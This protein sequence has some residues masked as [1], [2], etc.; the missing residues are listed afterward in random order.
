LGIIIGLD[1]HYLETAAA[2]SEKIYRRLER[3]RRGGVAAGGLSVAEKARWSLPNL[4]R[5]GGVGPLAWRQLVGALR[6]Y[7]WMV[8]GAIFLFAML[9]PM[10]VL[11]SQGDRGEPDAILAVFCS[12]TFFVALFMP[13]LLTFDFRADV[14]RME[15]LKTL[16][17]PAWRIVVGQMLIPVVMVT[18]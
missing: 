1:A 16:P 12:M 8:T 11:A 7:A 4:P 10:L 3:I 6:S 14:D 15:V 17:L 2:A 9:A 18:L 13:S 5:W